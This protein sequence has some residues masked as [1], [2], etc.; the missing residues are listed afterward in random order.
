V[1]D[2]KDAGGDV[3]MARTFRVTAPMIQVR[4]HVPFQGH[5][6]LD[7]HLREGD[8]VPEWVPAEETERLL[9]IGFIEVAS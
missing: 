9:G 1:E 7:R 4:G 8:I 2:T 3:V 5:A 6:P